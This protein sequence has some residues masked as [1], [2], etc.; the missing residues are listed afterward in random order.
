MALADW[1]VV[2]VLCLVSLAGAL[3]FGLFGYWLIM[4]ILM[5]G[6]EMSPGRR[7]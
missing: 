5:A 7:D 6:R 1:L 4:R 3:S 2:A